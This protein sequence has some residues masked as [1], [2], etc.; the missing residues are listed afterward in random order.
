MANN[1]ISVPSVLAF[2]R[3]IAC[4]DAVLSQGVFASIGDVNAWTPIEVQEKSIRGVISN[5]LKSNDEKSMSN[6]NLQKIDYASLSNMNDT[7]R[8]DFT[9]KVL[10]GVDKTSAC[11][12]FDF[13]KVIKE[14]IQSVSFDEFLELGKLYAY[15]ILSASFLWRNRLCADKVKTIVKFDNGEF[16]EVD[17]LDYSLKDIK[18]DGNSNVEKLG[19]KI[20]EVLAGKSDFLLLT[21]ECY[22][23]LGKGQEVYPSQELTQAEKSKK[24]LYSVID[25]TSSKHAA[26]H[27][28]KIGNAVRTIDIWHPEYAEFG[29]IAVEVYGSVTNIGKAFRSQK[30]SDFYSL[31]DNWFSK[32]KDLSRNERLYVIACLIRGGVYGD[33]KSN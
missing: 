28:Q 20:A 10:S 23:Q 5:R 29:P 14:K 21:V 22:A 16:I 11:N 32:E 1:K 31:F 26:I 15:S 17:S 12:S 13:I 4:S 8:L 18:T 33:V 3:K 30:G 7:L 25:S 9:V 6:S 19:T 27:S 24:V 2:E